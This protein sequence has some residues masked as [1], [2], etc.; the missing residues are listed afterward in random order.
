M[1]LSC[2]TPITMQNLICLMKLSVGVER[3]EGIKWY[4]IVVV[5]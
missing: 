3:R 2:F 1:T 5:I 4:L